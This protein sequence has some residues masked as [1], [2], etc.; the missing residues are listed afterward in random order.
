MGGPTEFWTRD[1]SE[2]PNAVVEC[3]LSDILEPIGDVPQQCYLSDHNIKRL[4]ERMEK[5]KPA[6]DT[7]LPMLRTFLGGRA[8]KRQSTRPSAA[9]R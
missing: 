5:Y 2:F 3:S 4:I 9:R 1:T 8:T 6:D 7:F